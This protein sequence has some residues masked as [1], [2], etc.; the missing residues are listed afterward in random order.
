MFVGVAPEPVAPIHTALSQTM[1]LTEWD[2]PMLIGI[3]NGGFMRSSVGENNLLRTLSR[4]LSTPTKAI[5]LHSV[6]E[7]L[8]AVAGTK[9]PNQRRGFQS[10][11]A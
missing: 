4:Y 6:E 11:F 10:S 1:R 9:E 8:N 3:D 5:Q 2:Q 7:L